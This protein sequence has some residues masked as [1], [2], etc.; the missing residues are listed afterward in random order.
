[1]LYNRRYLEKSIN[2]LDNDANLPLTIMALDVNG[3]KLTND[4]FGHQ[5]GDQLLKTVADILKNTCRAEDI[6]CRV[7]GDEFIVLLLNADE[8]HAEEVRRKII[9]V[10]TKVKLD[11]IM[12]SLA[13]GYAI[14]QNSYED[15]NTIKKIA[16]SNMYKNKAKHGRIMRSKTI[17]T[18]IQSI[19]NNYEQEQ[20][21]TE[22]VSQY[23]EAIA[24]E[25]NLNEKDIENIKMAG[26]LHDIGKIILPAELLSK[27]EK[28]TEEEF[29][30]IK[31]HPE[32]GYQILKSVDEYSSI[33]ELV[34]Y[35]HERFD[36]KG[37]PE[38]LKAQEIPFETRIISVADAYEAMTA[39]RPYQKMRSKEEAVEELKRCSG[40]Q[41]DPAVVNVFIEKVLYC[42]E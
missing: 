36:G 6:I 12:V 28:L 22:R 27:S 4:A 31:K 2:E 34:L 8:D 21:H 25:M 29:E 42:S 18:V 1:G 26:M 30:L 17:E 23:C 13:I 41:F 39:K 15:I 38:G 33:A 40:T 5:M 9:D 35:H 11:S 24:R 19:N 10:S 16:D 20:I 3:L 32:T 14:K 37:Y 7:G